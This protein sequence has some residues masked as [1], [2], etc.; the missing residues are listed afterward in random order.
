MAEKERLIQIPGKKYYWLQ[1]PIKRAFTETAATDGTFHFTT[2][3]L[4]VQSGLDENLKGNVQK[5]E[6]AKYRYLRQAW[7]RRG[8][9]R[10]FLMR[11]STWDQASL[12]HNRK[13]SR[14]SLPPTPHLT[15]SPP[16]IMV[17]EISGLFFKLIDYNDMEWLFLERSLAQRW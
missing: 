11:I 13:Q 4:K 15:L 8:T 12:R 14:S 17:P 1:L 16:P 3:P 6:N 10:D 5:A 7:Q 9:W 2:A